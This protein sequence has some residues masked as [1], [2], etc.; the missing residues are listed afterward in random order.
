MSWCYAIMKHKHENGDYYQI[1]EIY[2][3]NP[4]VKK[5]KIGWT[6]D[7]IEPFGNTP[8]ELIKELK[9]M[10][11]NAKKCPIFEYGTGKRLRNEKNKSKLQKSRTRS[12]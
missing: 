9:I 6:T 2:F 12:K 8:E 7:A 11:D 10:L 3:D 4:I 5:G 1:H